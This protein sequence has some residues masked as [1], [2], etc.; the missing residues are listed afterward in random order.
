MDL[1]IG[2]SSMFTKD[3]SLMDLLDDK[4]REQNF[5]DKL[6][7]PPSAKSMTFNY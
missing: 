1:F 2:N 3:Q 6:S 7:I 4:T 5:L